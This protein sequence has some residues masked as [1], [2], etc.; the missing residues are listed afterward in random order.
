MK[1]L[2]DCST[3][4]QTSFIPGYCHAFRWAPPPRGEPFKFKNIS[5][6]IGWDKMDQMMCM[7]GTGPARYTR[8]VQCEGQKFLAFEKLHPYH[9]WSIEFMI[10]SVEISSLVNVILI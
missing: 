9:G 7:L 6:R 1:K 3:K 2:P 10:P 5:R 4:I 8:V